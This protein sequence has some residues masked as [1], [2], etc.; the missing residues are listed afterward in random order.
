MNYFKDKKTLRMTGIAAK[1][2]TR[3]IVAKIPKYVT[4]EAYFKAEEKSLTKHEYHNGLITSMA[5][6]KLKHNQ[7]AQGVANILGNFFFD[8]NLNYIVSNSDTKIRIEA[9]N[10]IVYPDALV[11][12]FPAEYFNGRK[13]LLS[14]R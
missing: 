6:A 1:T 7:L 11:V 12:S 5:G 3:E 8:N 14:I 9:F 10:K 4:L 2:G 13:I